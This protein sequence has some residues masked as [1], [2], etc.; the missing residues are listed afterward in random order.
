MPRPDGTPTIAETL[1]D[2]LYP[3]AV[4]EGQMA[5]IS[6]RRTGVFKSPEYPVGTPER[7]EW[8]RGWREGAEDEI[9]PW[10]PEDDCPTCPG[11][12]L[13]TEGHPDG[14][15]K[16]SCTLTKGGFT[17]PVQRESEEFSPILDLKLMDPLL[18]PVM[19]LY[20]IIERSPKVRQPKNAP[21]SSGETLCTKPE[22]GTQPADPLPEGS[23]GTEPPYSETYKRREKL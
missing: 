21:V 3:E 22:V 6:S 1:Y 17:L 9:P 12:R 5:N 11:H 4:H 15:H 2:S 7:E 13:G 20:T 19:D 8:E 16:M 10:P 14:A 23:A 18:G